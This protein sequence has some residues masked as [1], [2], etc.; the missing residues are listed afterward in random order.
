MKENLKYNARAVTDLPEAIH[1]WSETS[2]VQRIAEHLA[3][4]KN[5]LVY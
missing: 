2:M 1:D 3:K 5:T 4:I